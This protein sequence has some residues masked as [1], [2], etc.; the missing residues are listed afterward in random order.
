MGDARETEKAPDAFRTISEVADELELPQHVLR[1]WESRFTQIKPVKRAG[2]RRFYRPEDVDLLRGIRHLLY[3]DGFTIKGA[4]RV[5]KDQGV[6]YVQDLG[7]ERE[8]ASMRSARPARAAG[9]EGVTFGG[10]LGLLPRRRGKG[11]GGEEDVLPELPESAEL[12]LPFPDAEADRDLASEPAAPPRPLREGSARG[13]RAERLDPAFDAPQREM[14]LR[15]QPLRDEPGIAAS[16]R[17]VDRGEAETERRRPDETDRRGPAAGRREP[18]FGTARADMDDLPPRRPA[19]R[20]EVDLDHD[21]APPRRRDPGLE[22]GLDPRAADLAARADASHADLDADEG[23]G[24]RAEPAL[25]RRATPEGRPGERVEP[26]LRPLQRPSRGPASR[27]AMPADDQAPH[28]PELDD[29]LLPFL[30]DFPPAPQVS[31]P[32]E[33]RIRRLKAQD[34][35]PPR[36]HELPE[37]EARHAVPH[38][39]EPGRVERALPERHEPEDESG[40]PEDFIPRRARRAPAESRDWLEAEP[41]YPRERDAR[42]GRLLRDGDWRQTDWVES[43]TGEPEAEEAGWDERERGGRVDARRDAPWQDEDWRDDGRWAD[44]APPEPPHE[45]YA[46]SGRPADD[47]WPQA[48]PLPADMPAPYR[49]AP[50]AAEPEYSMND[51]DRPQDR[52]EDRPYDRFGDRPSD[53][54]AFERPADRPRRPDPRAGEARREPPMGVAPSHALRGEAERPAQ[55]EPYPAETYGP[56]EVSARLPR[57]PGSWQGEA[58]RRAID[59][60]WGEGAPQALPRATRVGPLIGPISEEGESGFPMPEAEQRLL[61][62]RMASRGLAPQPAAAAPAHA[63][64]VQPARPAAERTWAGPSVPAEEAA[65]RPQAEPSQRL[66]CEPLR[67]GP[68]EQYLPP[69]LRSEPRVVGQPPMAAPVLSR[70]DVHR[71]QSALYELGECRRLM[72]GLTGRRGEAR[73]AD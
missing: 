9:G 32:I 69:H 16:S 62:E 20:P 3:T 60:E 6:R 29:P 21:T 42:D 7:I 27:L 59:E 54:R 73:T 45:P 34:R 65:A 4:Q 1:F 18:S 49:P 40:P 56:G 13:G 30:D 5:L 14:P 70:D 52:S 8:V 12:P 57:S 24:R 46:P 17:P 38:A 58:M 25:P 26:Q 41:Q 55:R 63:A 68:P 36:P 47:P 19:Q 39:P 67:P 43:T 64:S 61:A 66:P 15:H 48:A 2:G 11:R 72:E 10:L 44:D 31:E 53:R 23:R 22:P 51:Q 35:R 28:S 37:H 71:M 33:D 50:R